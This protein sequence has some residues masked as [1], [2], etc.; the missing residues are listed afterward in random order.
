MARAT[1]SG[2]P[3]RS[4]G[5]LALASAISLKRFRRG[6]MRRMCRMW[7]GSVLSA[8]WVNR[9]DVR[10]WA[11][12][13]ARAFQDRGGRP[14]SELLTEAKVRA[15]ITSDPLLRRDTSL[16]DLRVDDGVVTLLTRTDGWPDPRDQMVTLKQVK[17]ITDVTT[18]RAPTASSMVG[19]R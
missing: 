9:A 19:G 5:G 15:A 2:S 16:A 14:I 11:G 7:I 10:R 13:V 3:A 8:M 1:S 18:R 6:W 17:G 12:F 4:I